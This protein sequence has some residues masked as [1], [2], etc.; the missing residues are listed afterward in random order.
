[1]RAQSKTSQQTNADL[2]RYLIVEK[3]PNTAKAYAEEILGKAAAKTANRGE[4]R[5]FN[6]VLSKLRYSEFIDGQREICDR[7]RS[8]GN[9]GELKLY[10]GAYAVSVSKIIGS[11]LV[12]DSVASRQIGVCRNA[13]GVNAASLIHEATHLMYGEDEEQAERVTTIAIYY[14]TGSAHYLAFFG[15]R[16]N[17]FSGYL[18]R[19]QGLVDLQNQ[20]D[21]AN[22]QRVAQLCTELNSRPSS[23]SA[24]AR[25]TA[26]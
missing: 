20:I 4:N 8:V 19:Y 14:A 24:S 21:P 25:A 23:Q 26:R 15:D 5:L 3:D 13:G 9:N 7:S 11:R 10:V 2:P 1:M 22:S 17:K 18:C 6:Y 16:S 12:H